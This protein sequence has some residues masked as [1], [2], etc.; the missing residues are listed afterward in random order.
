[1]TVGDRLTPLSVIT[2]SRPLP[3]LAAERLG[4]F[5]EAGLDVR[6][7]ITRGSVEQIRG[8]LAGRWDVAHTAADNVMA[9]NDREAAGLRVVWV[10][11]LG[12]GQKLFVQPEIPDY[13]ALRGTRLGVDALD[14]GYAFV[15][16]K[17]L[18]LHGLEA[19]AYELVS[20]GGTRERF[21]ALRER[22][23]AGGL[24]SAPYDTAAEDAGFRL[25]DPASRYFPNYPGLTVAVTEG[26]LAQHKDLLR[27]YLAAL[28]RGM[29]YGADPANQAELI[30]FVAEDQGVGEDAARRR[31]QAERAVQSRILPSLSEVMSALEGVRRLRNEMTD[32]RR[33]VAESFDDSAWPQ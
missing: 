23:V 30:R 29:A 13:A 31:Y 21:E 19:D 6:Y 10:G 22:A 9:Y 8:L 20:V 16:R 24:L 18:A 4:F 11:D 33:E 17:M 12:L 27:R 5:Q 28:R 3:V 25:L 7:T 15:L 2:F 26:F 32:V 14:T 1:M